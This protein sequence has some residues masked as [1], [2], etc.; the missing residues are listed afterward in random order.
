MRSGAK[1]AA[2]RPAQARA[3]PD[4]RFTWQWMGEHIETARGPQTATYGLSQ[5]V[6]FFGKRGLQG[7]I[8]ENEAGVAAEQ[9]R[10]MEFDVVA[11]VRRVAAEI[12]YLDQALA[13]QTEDRRLLDDIQEIANT[14]YTTGQGRLGDV[15]RIDVELAEREQGLLDLD[16]DRE[17][18]AAELNRLLGRDAASP[19]PAIR[20]GL[21]IGSALVAADSL[22]ARGDERPELRAAEAAIAR[23]DAA[24]KLA[25]RSYFPDLM[26]GAQYLVVDKGMSVSPEAGIDAW[27]IEVGVNLPIWFGK[28][29]SGVR[30]AR[31]M[32]SQSRASLAA[33]RNR[34]RSEITASAA[35]VERLRQVVSV[36]NERLIP[37]AELA[38]RSASSSYRSGGIGFLDLLDT[39][40]ALIR[41]RLAAAR[42]Q[43]DLA[44]AAAE[45]ERATARPLPAPGVTP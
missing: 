24:A 29:R 18:A 7:D 14:R 26:L 30:E 34:I 27:M 8:A 4:P 11:Q 2:E 44:Q 5:E 13:I 12:A 17:A 38:L 21:D 19:V 10:A 16:R 42:A 40:R 1:A 22:A 45:L 36:Q 6:P 41:A 20:G 3:L 32:Q 37:K 15:A 23:S 43:A 39:E 31:H 25:R 33:E 35:R 9:V 28:L